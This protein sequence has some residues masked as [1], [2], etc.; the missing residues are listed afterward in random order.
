M[1][2]SRPG[3]V[4]G[5]CHSVEAIT[6][7][8]SSLSLEAAVSMERAW[9]AAQLGRNSCGNGVKGIQQLTRGQTRC[10]STSHVIWKFNDVLHKGPPRHALSLGATDLY[11]EGFTSCTVTRDELLSDWAAL[12]CAPGIPREQWRAGA[13]HVCT[14]TQFSFPTGCCTLLSGQGPS[15]CHP[16]RTA[17][18]YNVFSK[19]HLRGDRLRYGRGGENLTAKQPCGALPFEAF[20]SGQLHPRPAVSFKEG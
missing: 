9:L 7:F 14:E 2:K 19:R 1:K 18:S 4:G 10:L 13:R 17:R 5:D 15:C 16:Q 12:L 11:L 8:P 6:L 20:Q 3:T